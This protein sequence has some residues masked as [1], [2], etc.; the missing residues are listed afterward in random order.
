MAKDQRLSMRIPA[1][2][3]HAL[4]RLAANDRRSLASYVEGVLAA[5]VAGVTKPI[6]P[7]DVRTIRNVSDEIVGVDISELVYV[8]D[9]G[10]T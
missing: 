1:G 5:H 7:P 10:N 6:G 9:D 8:P 2:L 4:D 3:R